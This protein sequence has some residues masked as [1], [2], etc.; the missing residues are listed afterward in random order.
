MRCLGEGKL[1]D[2]TDWRHLTGSANGPVWVVATEDEIKSYWDASPTRCEHPR[3]ELRDY[4]T[5]NGGWQRK[6]QC[7]TCGSS[8]S[9]AKTR[10]KDKSVPLWDKELAGSWEAACTAKQKEIMEFL[11]D[12]TNNLEL[13]G[14]LFY[15]DYLKSPEWSK[16]RD[17]VLQRDNHLCQSCLDATATEVHHRSYDQ[18]FNEYLFD[19]VSV[20][21]I[22][23]ERMHSK[24]IA[25]VEAARAKGAL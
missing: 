5:S 20:C 10:D 17:L 6:E 18:I 9:N 15:E 13:K 12:R 2:N 22:C 4:Q 3:S 14:Y 19:L 21:R 25:A 24:K 8:T 23:H 1:G 11:V 16:K 7:L